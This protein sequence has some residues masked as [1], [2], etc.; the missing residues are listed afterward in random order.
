M[1]SSLRFLTVLATAMTLA[2]AT[3]CGEKEDAGSKAPV[4][5]KKPKPVATT[6][7]AAPSNPS[8]AE[9]P[10]APVPAQPAESTAATTSTAP[11]PPFKFDESDALTQLVNEYKVQRGRFPKSLDE[12][13]TAGLTARLPAPPA[14]KSFVL[15]KVGEDSMKVQIR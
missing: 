14:G 8:A 9:P 15:V 12:L 10:P 6:E 4:V 13:V 5:P 2:L 1:K 7:A 3:G 11:P